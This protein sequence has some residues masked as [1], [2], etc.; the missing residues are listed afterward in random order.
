MTRICFF[1]EV[2]TTLRGI[3]TNLILARKLYGYTSFLLFFKLKDSPL[4]FIPY[5][6]SQ[7]KENKKMGNFIVLQIKILNQIILRR[8][9]SPSSIAN[10]CFSHFFAKKFIIYKK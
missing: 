3:P 8:K 10:K 2:A 4:F 6:I 7:K 5:T 1:G 9:L